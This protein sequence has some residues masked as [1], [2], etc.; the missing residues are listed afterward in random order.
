[1]KRLRAL[2]AHSDLGAGF[3]LAMRDLEIRGAGTILGARQS[4]FIEELGYDL[5]QK[6]LEEAIA[7]LKGLE[8]HKL[9]E[10][11]LETDIEIHLPDFYVND[12]QHKVD[13]YRRL[14]NCRT[15]DEVEHIRDEVMDRFGKPPESAVNLF[16]ATA[17][18]IAAAIL[19][20]EKIILRSGKAQLFFME[21]RTLQRSEVEA[22]RKVCDQP[23]EFSLVGHPRIDI[24]F[25][26]IN[27]HQRMAY[28]KNILSGI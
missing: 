12:K 28:L 14:A 4:G 3:A 27:E 7:K 10:T 1:V 17:A 19:E 26:H 25:G 20:I 5:Y 22:L 11:R 15:L 13:I 24:D 21:N 2:E 9:P 18:K 8:I 6:L 23:M 16:D